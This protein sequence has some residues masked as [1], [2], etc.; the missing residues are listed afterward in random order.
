VPP[1]SLLVLYTDGL[2]EATRDVIDGEAR[3]REALADRRIAH[4][5]NP[6][7]AILDAVLGGTSRDDVAIL[8]MRV[9]P[10]ESLA[11]RPPSER[12][13]WRFD[14]ADVAAAQT[15]RREF[16][17]FLAKGDVPED[18]LYA[19]ELVF[20]ELISNVVRYAPGPVAVTIDW[21]GTAPVL[22]VLDEGPGF[23]HVARLPSDVYSER[24]RGLFLIASLTE[25]FHVARRADR[26]SHARAVLDVHRR[27][28]SKRLAAV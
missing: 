27:V 11:P 23:Q 28:G 22:H 6:A 21:T 12:L 24:G 14:S 8:T 13:T 15:A 1:D 7:K 16:A 10:I 5:P 19:A 18:E 26:G 20:G 9:A 25:D 3:V 4:A 2:T 17:S